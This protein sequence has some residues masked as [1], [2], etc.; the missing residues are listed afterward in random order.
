MGTTILLADDESH[1]TRIV[2]AKFR[3]AGFDALTVADGAEALA[4]AQRSLPALIVT[5]LQ[6]PRMSGLHLAIQLRQ[7]PRTAAIPIIL[8]TARGHVL[9]PAEVERTGIRR[10][11]PKPFSAREVLRAAQEIIGAPRPADAPLTDT[12]GRLAA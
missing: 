1:I 6:M 7:D 2:A 12:H 11:I 5:D 3:A 8:L 9:D 4:A 10:V